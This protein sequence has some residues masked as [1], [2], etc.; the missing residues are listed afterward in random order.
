MAKDC[1]SV[2]SEARK[3]AYYV[4][5]SINIATTSNPKLNPTHNPNPRETSYEHVGEEQAPNMVG[6]RST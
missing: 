3:N 1:K 5:S 4:R 6:I 2:L